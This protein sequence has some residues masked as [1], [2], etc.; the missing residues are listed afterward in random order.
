MKRR[1]K[2]VQSHTFAGMETA[3]AEQLHAA[4]VQAGEDLTAQMLEP[5]AD[6]SARAGEMERKSPL[7]FGTGDNPGLF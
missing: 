6:I 5:L 1:P 7:F 2:P 4:A 3:V